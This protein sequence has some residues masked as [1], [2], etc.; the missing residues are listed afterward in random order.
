MRFWISIPFIHRTRIGLSVS[1]TEIARAFRRRTLTAEEQRA[2]E[3]QRAALEAALDAKAQAF[4]EKWAPLV[5]NAILIAA[6]TILIGAAALVIWWLASFMITP[7]HAG[8]CRILGEGTDT[9]EAC[10]DGS[11]IVTDQH[12]HRRVYGEP[13]A[14][15]ERYPG[16][17]A[18]PV[19]ERRDER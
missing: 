1:D 19:Y 15:F 16:Q 6:A 4:A 10:E 14:G 2:R 11:F 17:G 3:E 13:N 12:G 8:T 9:V 5:A 18:R 7:S